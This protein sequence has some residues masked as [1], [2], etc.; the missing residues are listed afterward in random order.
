MNKILSSL[1]VLLLFFNFFSANVLATDMIIEKPYYP[2]NQNSFGTNQFYNVVFDGEGQAVVVVKINIQNLGK[3]AIN[4]LTLEIPGKNVRIISS[5]QEFYEKEQRC[6]YYNYN[7]VTYAKDAQCTQYDSNGECVKTEK[8]CIKQ[9]Q[10][11]ASWYN[12]TIYP[13]KY[14][15][16][17]K[18]EEQLSESKRV[19]F[20]LD[21]AIKEQETT[22]LILYYKTDGLASENLGVFDF[23]FQTIKMNFDTQQVRVSVGVN[24]DLYFEGGEAKVNYQPNFAVFD[25]AELMSAKGIQSQELSDFSRNI[26]YSYGYVKTAQG[27]DPWESFSVKGKYA[28]S[29]FALQK[30]KIFSVSLVVLALIVGFILGIVRLLKFKKTSLPIAVGFS[31]L[32]SSILVTIVWFGG[33]KLLQLFSTFSYSSNSQMFILLLGLMWIILLLIVLFAPSIYFG[34]KQGIIP[35]IIC[36]LGTI[37]MLLIINVALAIIFGTLANTNYYG[38]RV[39]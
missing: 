33:I 32:A 34:V 15:N 16:L 30:W 6:S 5:L 21:V 12:Q 27:L 13:P 8:I 29:W 28:T 35:A 17:E 20:K 4:D 19:K 25:K 39:Y 9:D 38:G 36:L 10:Q 31:S 22:T 7:C 37:M 18:T 3:D 1:F 11:C 26:E 14:Y 24:P 2:Y 23:D